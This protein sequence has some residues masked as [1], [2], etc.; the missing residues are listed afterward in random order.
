KGDSRRVLR[1]LPGTMARKS[2][3]TQG[4]PDVVSEFFTGIGVI[5]GKLSEIFSFWDFARN[6]STEFTREADFAQLLHRDR[7]LTPNGAAPRKRR[8]R[9]DTMDRFIRILART[10]VVCAIAGGLGLTAWSLMLSMG[11]R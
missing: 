11:P 6:E 7:W 8:E 9:Q 10:F 5:R 3:K 4:T 2:G 1:H